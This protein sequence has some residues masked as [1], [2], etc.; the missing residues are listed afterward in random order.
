M[1]QKLILCAL[2][3]LSCGC[4]NV[5]YRDPS[6]AVFTRHAFANHVDIG[7]VS[8]DVLSTNGVHKTLTI[9]GYKN[10]Q[11]QGLQVFMDGAAGITKAA[12][13]G[14]VQGAKTP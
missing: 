4:V 12:V 13:V 5:S 3:A 10:D 1:K 8:V 6:G 2:V 9:D 11:V 7:H 14:A